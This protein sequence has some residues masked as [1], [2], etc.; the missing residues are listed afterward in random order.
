MNEAFNLYISITYT[1]HNQPTQTES[2]YWKYYVIGWGIP[3][4]LVA[5]LVGSNFDT[6]FSDSMCW[7]SWQNIWLFA[8]PPLAMITVSQYHLSTH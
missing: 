7:V 6:Y 1:A 4:V 2:G 8:A 5:A 3:G